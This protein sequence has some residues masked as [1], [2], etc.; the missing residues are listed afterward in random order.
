MARPKKYKKTFDRKEENQ[1]YER[2]RKKIGEAEVFVNKSKNSLYSK[3]REKILEK[4]L[5]KYRGAIN[6]LQNFPNYSKM[7]AEL[8]TKTA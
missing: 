1:K 8:Y 2:A 7:L 4:A 5:E 6:D 3:D